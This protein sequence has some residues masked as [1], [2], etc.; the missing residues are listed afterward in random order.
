MQGNARFDLSKLTRNPEDSGGPSKESGLRATRQARL[1]EYS[2][3][4]LFRLDGRA[5][6]TQEQP[7]ARS[8]LS[9]EVVMGEELRYVRP[10]GT[11]RLLFINSAPVWDETGAVVASVVTFQDIKICGLRK[12]S[13][14]AKVMMSS[15]AQFHVDPWPASRVG[16]SGAALLWAR[17]S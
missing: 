13:C 16:G 14:F 6:N 11:F 15:I 1:S 9:G 3:Y 7:L 4:Q 2:Q 10:D 8:V 17:S 12:K 5:Y